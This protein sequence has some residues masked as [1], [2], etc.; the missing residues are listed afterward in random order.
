ME[1]EFHIETPSVNVELSQVRIQ[2]PGAKPSGSVC[3][4]VCVGATNMNTEAQR[5]TL[6]SV[7][8]LKY[9]RLHK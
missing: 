4:N 7:K 5:S 8:T 6:L 3:G 9:T 1:H 2:Y